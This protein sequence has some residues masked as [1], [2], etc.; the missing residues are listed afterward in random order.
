MNLPLDMYTIV[1]DSLAG[2]KKDIETSL[3]RGVIEA[4]K[5]IQ[6]GQTTGVLYSDSLLSIVVKEDPK[7]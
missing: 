6:A 3:K 4:A 1:E 7:S 2:L 5:Q